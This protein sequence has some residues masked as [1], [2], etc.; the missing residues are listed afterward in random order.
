MTLALTVPKAS[1]AKDLR[2]SGHRC[3]F[4][5]L[6]DD[7]GNWTGDWNFTCPWEDSSDFRASDISVLNIE[8][9]PGQ[10]GTAKACVDYWNTGGGECGP[11]MGNT[12]TLQPLLDAWGPD[13]LGHFKYLA[14]VLRLP[15][16]AVLI[17][18]IFAF[19]P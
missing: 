11:E 16:G 10:Q 3:T 1:A 13:N 5:M 15:R 14:G 4:A 8:L 17:K 12:K 2:Y 19:V 9:N 18:G 6:N 7:F